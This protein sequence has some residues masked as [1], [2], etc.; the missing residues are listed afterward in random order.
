MKSKIVLAG[1]FLFGLLSPTFG[2]LTDTF[3]ATTSNWGTPTVTAVGPPANGSSGASLTQD[4]GNTRVDWAVALAGASNSSN[5]F[6]P[7]QSYGGTYDSDWSISFDIV[8][9]FSAGTGQSVQIGLM[10][11]NATGYSSNSTADYLKLVLVQADASYGGLAQDNVIHY[12]SHSNTAADPYSTTPSAGSSA[13]LKLTYTAASNILAAYNNTTLLHSF[14][15][16]GSGGDTSQNWGMSGDDGFV[17]GLYAQATT[18]SSGSGFTLPAGS[19]YAD[20]FTST[21]LTAVPEPSTYAL[22][23]GL[24][25]LGLAVWRKKHSSKD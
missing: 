1:L 2:Q 7:L 23:F 19:A 21:G 17:I 15:I 4:N 20:S 9:G 6:M 3:S 24:A 5:L 22:L 12:G 14:G 11:F 16:G 10:A 13:T 25:G 8:N 18:N